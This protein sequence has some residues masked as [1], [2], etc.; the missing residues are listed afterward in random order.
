MLPPV[1][2]R[3]GLP[4]EV[5]GRACERRGLFHV[6]ALFDG[7][8]ALASLCAAYDGNRRRLGSETGNQVLKSVV[9]L[10]FSIGFGTPEIYQNQWKM[11][12]EIHA[13]RYP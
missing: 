4:R 5:L 6:R 2:K 12:G 1:P 3:T 13:T 10:A 11:Q 7:P 8:D 9:S